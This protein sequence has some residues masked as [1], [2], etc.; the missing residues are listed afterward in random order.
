MLRLG[1]NQRSPLARDDPCQ[2]SLSQRWH[3]DGAADV[4]SAAVP[5]RGDRV[6]RDT[7]M[8]TGAFTY[9]EKPFAEET[10]MT[11]LYDAL[12]SQGRV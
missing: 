12:G 2:S 6:T 4:R 11:V 9:L 1:V 5:G 8:G 7:V 10:L 3:C